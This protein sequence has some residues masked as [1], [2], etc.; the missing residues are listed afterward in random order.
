M[1]N[2][3][4]DSPY[5]AATPQDAVA[6]AELVDIAGEG[7]PLHLWTGMAGEGESPWQIGQQRALRESGGF[8]YRN[9]VVQQLGDTI[10][11]A[12]IGYALPDPPDLIHYN[13]L[14]AVFVPL[15][16]LEDM[17]PGTWYINVLAAYPEH[18]GKGYGT[19]LLAVAERI[20][21]QEKC[22]GL[23]LIVS[24]GNPRA[25]Q[26]YTRCGYKDIA[27]RPMVK[28]SWENAGEDWILLKKAL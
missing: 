3:I 24:D 7:M 9:T 11:A 18:R 26:L 15:Q 23:S 27:S 28:D 1:T 14:P 6:M 2:E 5:R 16:Q 4:L 12:L 21:V 20:A 17:V 25:W 13:E 22:K 19:G 10:V 8:S